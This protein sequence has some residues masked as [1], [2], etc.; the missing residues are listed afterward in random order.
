MSMR[1]ERIGPDG[2]LQIRHA[3]LDARRCHPEEVKTPFQV[4]LVGLHVLGMVLQDAG[5]LAAGQFQP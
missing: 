3:G 5:A 1:I 2:L 4:Q